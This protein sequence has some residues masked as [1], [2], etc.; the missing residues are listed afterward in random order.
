MSADLTVVA[1][2]Y[3][4][5]VPAMATFLEKLGLTPR[6]SSESGGFVT[7]NA[8]DGLVMLHSASEALS[9]MPAGSAE[10]AFEAVDLDAAEQLLAPLE[11]V[12]WDES[13]GQHLGFRDPRGDGIWV[14]ESQRDLYGYRAHDAAPNDLNLLA[15][16]FTQDMAAEAQF[17]R[18]F[19]YE[20]RGP[21]S[22]HF[23]PLAGT[24][25]A[26][27]VIG[28]HPPNPA[29]ATGPQSPDNPVGPPAVITL[30]FETH[31]PLDDLQR[32][33]NAVGIDARPMGGPAPHLCV[34]DPEGN[35]IE[36]HIAP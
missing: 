31:E 17:Y 13:Y 2:R 25:A 14:I 21:M 30:S 10:L 29:L 32:R 1:V 35:E 18:Q 22:E 19:G 11:P 24:G 3:C 8:G 9:G 7:L 23:T 6:L 34:D 20:V 26:H 12:R 36:L 15:I 5:D 28:L 33:L 27:G 16:R 4:A